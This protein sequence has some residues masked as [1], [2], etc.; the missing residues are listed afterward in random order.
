MIFA[1][2]SRT[3]IIVTHGY[4][5]LFQKRLS[6]TTSSFPPLMRFG[7]TFFNFGVN[8]KILSTWVP[9]IPSSIA[10]P[11]STVLIVVFI[12]INNTSIHNMWCLILWVYMIPSLK[13]DVKFFSPILFHQSVMFT[14]ALVKNKLGK[15]LLILNLPII[16]KI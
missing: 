6:Q 3:N 13:S 11:I 14:L 16:M 15:K 5:T 10:N 2:W 12:N 4:T 7:I 9:I 8:N 1:T